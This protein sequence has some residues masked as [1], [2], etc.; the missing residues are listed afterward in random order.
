MSVDKRLLSVTRSFCSYPVDHFYVTRMKRPYSISVSRT[1]LFSISTKPRSCSL[2]PLRPA[3]TMPARSYTEGKM[4]VVEKV[5]KKEETWHH[6]LLCMHQTRLL[7]FFAVPETPS[8]KTKEKREKNAWTGN[9]ETG[10]SEKCP[11]RNAG[12]KGIKPREIWKKTRPRLVVY[13]VQGSL[14]FLSSACCW[15]RRKG[16]EREM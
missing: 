8:N 13:L 4:Q 15:E 12:R 7:R 11:R 5:N 10:S 3:S 6:S 14:L 2:H 1:V 9:R 16:R